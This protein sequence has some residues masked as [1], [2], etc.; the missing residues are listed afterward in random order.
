MLHATMPTMQGPE[1]AMSDL[2]KDMVKNLI[3]DLQTAAG[4]VDVYEVVERLRLLTGQRLRQG[5][6]SLET[7][8]CG[9]RIPIPHL[10]QSLTQGL[11]SLTCQEPGR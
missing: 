4:P 7:Q 3:R 10:S 9:M 11:Q 2:P 5:L 1:Q 8:I 6:Q